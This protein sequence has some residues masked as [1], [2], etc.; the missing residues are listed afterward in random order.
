MSFDATQRKTPEE[1]ELDKKREELASLEEEVAQRELDLATSV[2]ELRAFERRYLRIVGVRMAE[3]D[4]IELEIAELMAKREPQDPKIVEQ[5][6]QARSRAQESAEATDQAAL[7]GQAEE[8]E[9]SSDLKRLYRDLAKRIHPDLA[10]DEDERQRRTTLMA[11]ANEAYEN[12]DN[13]RLEQ[14]LREWEESPEGVE[15]EG[16]AA[17]LVRAIR[18]VAQVRERL[19]RIESEFERLRTADLHLIWTKVQATRDAGPDLLEQMASELDKRILSARKVLDGLK[20][21]E[22]VT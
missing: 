11:D 17:D 3:L 1:E 21:Q 5:E 6:A 10:I 19:S 4:A 7:P 13:A 18:K 12:G 9:P 16:V 15:G 14:I 2:A 20:R 8:F 22:T